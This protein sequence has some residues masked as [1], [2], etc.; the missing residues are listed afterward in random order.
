MGKTGLKAEETDVREE[1]GC[2]SSSDN[3]LRP[4]ECYTAEVYYLLVQNITDTSGFTIS[5][6]GS[7]SFLSSI[8][9]FE[10]LPTMKSFSISKIENNFC[11]YRVLSYAGLGHQNEISI[12]PNP[13]NDVLN[14]EVVNGNFFSEVA[15][16]SIQGERIITSKDTASH[17]LDISRLVPGVYILRLKGEH[18]YHH[19]VWVKF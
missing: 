14:W 6:G 17:R 18:A 4:L 11:Q 12:Y 8:E 15:I 9:E 16:L 10:S 13:A 2:L 1:L 7:A 5:F 3:Y 19:K